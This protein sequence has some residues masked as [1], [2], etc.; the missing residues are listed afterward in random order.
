MQ[1]GI[2][3]ICII[4]IAEAL[5]VILEDATDKEEVIQI[6]CSTESGLDVDP[7]V[8]SS[9]PPEQSNLHDGIIFSQ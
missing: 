2:A 3:V 8:V 1:R 4:R 5:R 9:A 6:D 7:N